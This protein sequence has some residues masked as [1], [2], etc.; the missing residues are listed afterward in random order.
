MA[1][2][3]LR[4]EVSITILIVIS[5][6]TVAALEYRHA[7]EIAIETRWNSGSVVR[8]VHP[9]RRCDAARGAS[10]L[11][12]VHAADALSPAAWGVASPL[13]TVTSSEEIRPMNR[14]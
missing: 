2:E 4:H 9:P 7:G 1:D 6:G 5:T 10:R 12:R 14:L 8:G 11:S 13:K 3:R